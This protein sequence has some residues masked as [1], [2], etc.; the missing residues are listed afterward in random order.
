M[1]ALFTKYSGERVIQPLVKQGQTAGMGGMYLEDAGDLNAARAA[2]AGE[3]LNSD[4]D[5][6]RAA[7]RREFVDGYELLC[8]PGLS[9]LAAGCIALAPTAESSGSLRALEDRFRALGCRHA[10]VYQQHAD[11][12]LERQFG[13]IGRGGN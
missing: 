5:Y 13:K 7:A 2:F 9:R 1:R 11:D 12:K 3:L 10:R 8:M 6:F 4:A